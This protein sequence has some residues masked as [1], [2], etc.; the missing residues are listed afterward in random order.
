MSKRVYQLAKAVVL[1][2][3][4]AGPRSALPIKHSAMLTISSRCS[5]CGRP[6]NSCCVSF[7]ISLS[8]ERTTV[9]WQ[10]KG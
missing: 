7:S 2:S 6:V 4:T 10:V 8:A 3:S 9:G 1:L 5:C